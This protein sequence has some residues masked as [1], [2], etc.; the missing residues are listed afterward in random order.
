MLDEGLDTMQGCESDWEV[1]PAAGGIQPLV[2]SMLVGV[3][4]DRRYDVD[5]VIV[6]NGSGFGPQK[7]V[8]SVPDQSKNP[9][10]RLLAAQIVTRTGQPAGFN[11]LS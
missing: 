6:S 11:R 3:C 10:H 1:T 2:T 7:R 4:V 8:G 9:T 5:R